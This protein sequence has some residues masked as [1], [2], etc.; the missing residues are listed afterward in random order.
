M[1]RDVDITCMH[2]T[3]RD[4][5]I[6]HHPCSLHQDLQNQAGALLGAGR[7]TMVDDTDDDDSVDDADD[8]DYVADVAH[9]KAGG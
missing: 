8:D 9:D 5:R 1:A 3:V 7:R 6:A 4:S 2:A